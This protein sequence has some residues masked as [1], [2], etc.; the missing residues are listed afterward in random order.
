[1]TQTLDRL[2][3]MRVVP[4]VE[5]DDPADAVPL[6]EALVAGGLACAEIVLRTPAALDVV[7]AIAASGLGM[8]VGAGTVRSPEQARDAV[9][10]GA[11]F[12]VSPSLDPAVVAAAA[13]LATPMLPGVCTPSEIDAASR[14]GLRVVKFFPAELSGGP[15]AIRALAGPFPEMRFM[16]TGGITPDTL[17][18]YLAVP[19]IVACGG[20]W[21]TDRSLL[22]ARDWDAVRERAAAAARTAGA[23]RTT[24]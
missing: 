13:E 22:A 16:P 14:L 9:A 12:L 18:D 2:E 21:I 24:A 10:A 8:T 23:Y 7:A 4:I 20:S 11:A 6:A 5:L 17:G 1:M 19:Q 15:A 3:A